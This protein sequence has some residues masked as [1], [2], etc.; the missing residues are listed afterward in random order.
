MAWLLRLSL[1]VWILI[2]TVV[3]IVVGWAFPEF[4][5]STAPLAD[6][7][8]RLIKLLVVPLIFGTLVVGIAGHGDDLSGVGRMAFKV[9]IY[10]TTTTIFAL[11]IA[12]TVVNT[13]RPGDGV[14]LPERDKATAAKIAEIEQ[15]EA[16][17]GLKDQSMLADLIRKAVPE[18]FFS[19]AATNQVLQVV[20]FAVLFASGLTMVPAERRQPMV[21][22]CDALAETML[23]VTK[24]VMYYAPIGIGAAIGV[25]VGSS[26]L[27]VLQTLAY[28]V[29]TL[30]F[31][32][33]LFVGLV[34]VPVMLL[35]RIPV[36]PFAREIRTPFLIAFTTASSEAALP[37]AMERLEK[38]GVPKRIVAFVMPTG[39]S[40]NL[41]GSTLYLAI[42][43]IFAAQAGGI[44]LSLPQQL[45]IM[46][47]LLLTSKGVAAVPR[48]SLVILTATLTSF[49]L[50]LEAIVLIMGVDAF[51]DMARTSVN[52]TGNCV[53]SCVIARWERD[54]EP[55]S[56]LEWPAVATPTP[57]P[58]APTQAG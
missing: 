2:A 44:E 47:T 22:F 17:A 31:A 16:K 5:V 46:G 45:L 24:I 12:L 52:L 34:L 20:V 50:P 3:G 42:A 6:L 26:G 4:A 55:G 23:K 28:M 18:S 41:D 10:F 37:L 51:M 1:T 9:A 29:G 7:F 58:A 49:N 39:Y 33:I 48:A 13:A 21:S 36:G 27:G 56:P 38:L 40:F 53:A 8:L 15:A 30:Y 32:L 35:W 54:V 25:A 43:S 57:P 11:T 14:K 19:A